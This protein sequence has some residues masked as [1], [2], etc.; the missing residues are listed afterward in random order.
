[1]KL[2]H[3]WVSAYV[4]YTNYR[5]AV[6]DFSGKGW[7]PLAP[8]I[9]KY[10]RTP[11]TGVL[12]KMGVS[13]AAFIADSLSVVHPTS[14]LARLNEQ[15]VDYLA[16]SSP[17]ETYEQQLG[18][19]AVV[20]ESVGLLP[21]SLPVTV[22]AVTGESAHLSVSH[23]QRVVVRVR[24]G[25]REDA[26]VVLEYEAPLHELLGERVTLSYQ[27]ATIDDHKTVNLFGGLDGVPL[28][29][30]RLRPRIQVR[31]RPE[32]VGRE[33]IDPGA[34]QRLEIEFTGPFGSERVT[35]TVVA[36]SYYAFGI[37]TQRDRK[38][39]DPGGDPGESEF[40]AARL[41][42][43][44]ALGYS[45]RWG[46]AEDELAGLLDVSVL[47]PLP[48]L[49]IAGNAV[50][51]HRLFDLPS[52]LEWQG[53]TLDAALRVAEPVDR[54]G[55]GDAAEWMR[56]AALEGSALENLVFS[57]EFLVEGI[58]ADK[59]LALARQSGALVL[60]IAAA[61]AATSIPLRHH[62]P[63][64]VAD[65]ENWIRLGAVVEIPV[66]PIALNAWQ[67]AVW[68]AEDPASGASAYLIAGGLAGGATTVPPSQW[69]LDF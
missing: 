29:L 50:E 4:P 16:E 46:A 21:A 12:K 24:S 37:T 38:E 6:V 7:V 10:S 35:Q 17:G 48:A 13:V 25:E 68:R 3:T 44:L 23:Q 63:E 58:S 27:P 49:V 5:G 47:R 31:G 67:G 62:A 26:P 45:V 65:V 15:V 66:D 54:S 20:P 18:S 32:A 57:E 41:L 22:V 69:I 56:L 59:G 40:L 28:Y 34:R 43:G 2:E 19:A 14:P 30:I 1:M 9:E 52:E 33:P 51:V 53:V 64:V 11:A 36:G 55:A 8:A 60:R 39:P 42:S 61:S